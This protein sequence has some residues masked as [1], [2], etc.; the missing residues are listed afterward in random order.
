MVAGA[1]QDNGFAQE[2]RRLAVPA[3]KV[4]D[5]HDVRASTSSQPTARCRKSCSQQEAIQFP[6]QVH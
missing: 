3:E 5:H 1:G 6:L 2:R 4:T